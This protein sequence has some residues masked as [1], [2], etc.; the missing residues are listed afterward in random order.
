[1]KC[2]NPNKQELKR[3]K[4]QRLKND[5]KYM[6]SIELAIFLITIKKHIIFFFINHDKNNSLTKTAI[7]QS[8]ATLNKLAPNHA[9]I[10]PTISARLPEI[11]D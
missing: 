3:K 1:M 10:I 8:K 6:A 11:C 5:Y 7:Q 2:P 9:D 4:V